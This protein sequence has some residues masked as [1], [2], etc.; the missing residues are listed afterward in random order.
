MK[1]GLLPE[2]HLMYIMKPTVNSIFRDH[3]KEF[4]GTYS[5]NNYT[6]KVIRAI[7]NC[8][9]EALGGH[10]RQCDSCGEKIIQYNSCRNRHC[11]QCQFM[12]K[13]QWIINRQNDV[14][15]F[16]YFH[17]VFTIPDKL[18]PIVVRNKKQM[19]TLLFNS[20]KKTLLSV[21]E[22]EKY[23]G[24]KIGFFSILHTWGQKLNLHPHIHC[25]VPGGG[26]CEKTNSWK[27][28]PQNYLVPI[29]VLQKRF[30]SLFLCG[31]KELYQSNVLFLDGTPYTEKRR[32]QQFI[33]LLF[34]IEWIVYMKESF[35]SSDSVIA[36]LS[37][38]THR[39]A[40]SNHRILSVI[41][42]IVTFSYRDYKDGK[43]KEMS[44]PVLKFMKLFL[45]HIVPKR[46][47]R[48]RYYGILSNS[49]KTKQVQ[50]C[51][52]YF[53]VKQKEIITQSWQQIFTKV[54]GKDIDVC[55]HCGQ[56]KLIIIEI[57][58]ALYSRDGP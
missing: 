32:F 5:V 30:R 24:A 14:L 16:Q 45:M 58:P 29:K 6:Y 19:Y 51:R 25:V 23:F 3:V 18:N 49:T 17:V 20:V 28:S 21:S 41:D 42:G 22:D 38:Y 39:I 7:T 4:L 31:L 40:I 35:K 12:K 54:T 43:K 46:F 47:V 1:N 56:G 10:I 8:R 50:L 57:L 36:Y 33:D 34:D 27:R 9:T 44:V 55:P 37:K 13:E 53:S 15:P 11:P 52:E 26:F 48:I 2:V